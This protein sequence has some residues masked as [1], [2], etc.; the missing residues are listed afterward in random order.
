MTP[1]LW[2]GLQPLMVTA[3]IVGGF[4]GIVRLSVWTLD[5]LYPLD[6]L[7]RAD[8]DIGPLQPPGSLESRRAIERHKA[9]QARSRGEEPEPAREWREPATTRCMAICREC[10]DPGFTGYIMA[11]PFDAVAPRDSWVKAHI[12]TQ[13]HSVVSI[14]GGWL[15]PRDVAGY[16]QA[17]DWTQIDE[18]SARGDG[19]YEISFKP[20]DEVWT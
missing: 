6:R 8:I 7:M 10:S 15:S 16:M 9:A 5:T 19:R 13:G 12:A 11:V 4:L 17:M 3:A 20:E 14:S 1:A 2:D 18:G